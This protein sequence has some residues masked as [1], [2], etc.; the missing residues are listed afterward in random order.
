MIYV[1]SDLHGCFYTLEKLVDKVRKKD[2]SPQFIFVG[3]YVDRGLNSKQ[4]VEFVMQ[5]QSEG[6][7]CLRGNHDDVI[8][9]LL[10]QESIT[11]MNE[12]TPDGVEPSLMSIG[13]WWIVNGLFPTVQSYLDIELQGNTFDFILKLFVSAVPIEHRKFFRSL[14]MHWEND[15]HFACHAFLDPT[16][17]LPRTLDFLPSSANH[18]MLW[19]RFAVNR[20][21]ML[22]GQ[23]AAGIG[24]PLPVWDKIGV[25][26]H[27]PVS[28]YGAFAPIKH[29]NLRL[30]D[31]GAFQ[32][33]YMTAYCAEQDSWLLQATDSR[34]LTSPKL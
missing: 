25:F 7:V 12:M 8:D 19:S 16:Q 34:D 33:E 4:C 22:Y 24:C 20:I 1:I 17:P 13:G 21:E 14:K 28:C 10:H 6:A 29:G 5:L 18:D 9:W 2:D 15:T 26:G 3:D 32:G 23:T 27:T 30:I 11:D 31:T